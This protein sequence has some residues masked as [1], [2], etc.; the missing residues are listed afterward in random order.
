M[1]S[2]A[3]SILQ[4]TTQRVEGKDGERPNILSYLLRTNQSRSECLSD[5]E[6]V[7]RKSFL[8]SPDNSTEHD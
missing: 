5:E 2:L 3:H 7:A 8:P 4:E 6:I 1:L